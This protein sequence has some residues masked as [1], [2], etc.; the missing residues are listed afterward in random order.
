LKRFWPKDRRAFGVAATAII[1]ATVVTLLWW[2]AAL[3]ADALTRVSAVA[4]KLPSR[5]HTGHLAP[6]FEYRARWSERGPRPDEERSPLATSELKQIA[7]ETSRRDPRYM[8]AVG[9]AMLLTGDSDGA[10]DVLARAANRERSAD[11]WSD[12][13][14]AHIAAEEKTGNPLHALDAISAADQALSID[15]RHAAATFNRAVALQHL[16]LLQESAAVWRK[17]LSLDSHSP[18]S[19]EA[20]TAAQQIEAE[21]EGVVTQKDAMQAIDA[22]VDQHDATVLDRVVRRY[23]RTARRAGETLYLSRWGE[24]WKAGDNTLGGSRLVAARELGES[25]QRTAGEKLLADSVSHIEASQKDPERMRRLADA[26]IEYATARRK[27]GD[28]KIQEAEASFRHSAQLFRE[29]G[30]PMRFVA[31]YSVGSA[32]YAEQR[33]PETVEVLDPLAAEDLAQR[34]YFGLAAQIGWERG[35]AY[36]VR[37]IFSTAHRSF[38]GSR[39]LFERLGESEA[40]ATMDAFLAECDDYAGDGERAWKVRVRAL[41]QLSK[42]GDA[43]RKLSTLDSAGVCFITRGE[44]K[45]AAALLD[46]SVDA[47]AKLRDSL[48]SADLLANRSIVRIAIGNDE[49]ARADLAQMRAWCR[50]VTDASEREAIE[51][52]GLVAEAELTREDP[53]A[54]IALLTRGLDRL[55]QRGRSYDAV[56]LLRERARVRRENGDVENAI[57]DIDTATRRLDAMRSTLTS[58]EARARMLANERSVTVEGILAGLAANRVGFAFEAAERWRGRSLLDR[59]ER[60]DETSGLSSR[61]MSDSDIARA[62]APRAAVVEYARVP[63]RLVIFV[64]RREGTTAATLPLS[65][66]EAESILY[67]ASN[68]ERSGQAYAAL[69]APVRSALTGIDTIAFVPDPDL[70]V[71]FPLLRDPAGGA[72]AGEQF[73]A[74]I[75]PSATMAI[76][77]SQVARR[78]SGENILAVS[79]DAFDVAR[80][81]LQPL[82]AASREAR[83]VA[84]LYPTSTILTGQEATRE[85]FMAAASAADII[86]FAGHAVADGA[87]ASMSEMLLASDGASSTLTAADIARW[88]LTHSRLVFLSACDS[89]APGTRGDGVENLADAFLVAGVPTVIAAPWAVDDATALGIAQDFHTTFRATGDAAEALHAVTRR[90]HS[91][92]N[93]NWPPMMAFGGLPQLVSQ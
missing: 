63:D 26:S 60:V 44:W 47:A 15:P 88:T 20:H 1:I 33:V 82:P 71:P 24:A 22:A 32:L 9:D 48:R 11:I 19:L 36:M 30:S 74:V 39:R 68:P 12:L 57:L 21:I 29:A 89:A 45:R 13:A 75:A 85:R 2:R 77:C 41:S 90:L 31:A 34:G 65:D 58:T 64:V 14:V 46:L 87:N 4:L 80:T 51:G 10:I 50:S 42:A 70:Q 18:W 16:G 25:L 84:R 53:A 43:P 38:D 52:R 76:R 7:Q 8:R 91:S 5:P 40:V 55:D 86:H 35:L 67:A 49:R 59:M 72:Y 3:R 93:K 78:Q 23:P 56:A 81:N 83:A 66:A 62:L 28:R 73:A 37:G 92:G 61:P 6:P 17:Y 54:S 27:Y 79:G 69:V